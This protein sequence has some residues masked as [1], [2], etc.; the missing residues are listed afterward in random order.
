M[1]DLQVIIADDGSTDDTALVAESYKNQVEYTKINHAGLPAVTRNAGLKFAHGEYIAFL[2]ADDSWLPEKTEKQLDA[3]R[4]FNGLASSTNAW[5]VR[6]GEND[7][8]YF[9]NTVPRIVTLQHLLSENLVICSSV[10][11]HRSVI[12]R[13][14]DFT[15]TPDMKAI[16][17]Y[18]MWLRVAALTT[19]V[20]LPESHTR[21]TDN[22][23]QSI[24]RDS[25]SV[26]EQK[27]RVLIDFKR[28]IKRSG[29]SSS[30]AA[31]AQKALILNS[32][33]EIRHNLREGF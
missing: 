12:A 30:L 26:Y 7:Q 15:E 13:T 31:Q 1:K 27:R 14:G 2:D 29:R 4:R 9:G 24:R 11:L 19:W 16:E 22:P 3:M 18:A 28:W 10:I 5:R 6:N 20:Y 25:I 21:Y 8:S 23:S 33:A 17:D 32:F